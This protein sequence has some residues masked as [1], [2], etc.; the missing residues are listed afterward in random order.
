MV[1]VSVLVLGC[2]GVVVSRNLAQMADYLTPCAVRE[3]V[4]H[5]P[6]E[7]RVSRGGG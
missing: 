4:R 1:S 3:V 2:I 7:V 6:R 5:A